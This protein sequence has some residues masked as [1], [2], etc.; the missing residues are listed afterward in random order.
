MSYTDDMPT[1]ASRKYAYAEDIAIMHVDGDWQAVEE[2]LR[3]NMATA[4]EQLQT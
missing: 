1:T 3:K 2:V 4:G